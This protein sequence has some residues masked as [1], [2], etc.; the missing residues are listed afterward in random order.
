M[1]RALVLVPL[2]AA[3]LAGTAVTLANREVDPSYA[4]RERHP[5]RIDADQVQRAV[6]TAPEPVPGRR[7]AARSARC[8]P[9]GGGD[10]RNPWTCTVAYGSGSRFTYSVQIEADGS[11]RGENRIGNR[12]VYGCCVKP[13]GAE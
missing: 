1:R 8:R 13:P 10:I 11:F 2:L 3:G 7:T 5:L 9:G 12:I 6:S 4:F